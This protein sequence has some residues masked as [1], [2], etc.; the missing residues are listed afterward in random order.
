MRAGRPRSQG[1]ILYIL[2]R[3]HGLHLAALSSTE[4]LASLNYHS[5]LEESV[6]QGP[7]RSR[8]GGGQTRAFRK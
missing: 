2:D 3:K 1:G 5:P 4:L 8:A 7:A 6:R